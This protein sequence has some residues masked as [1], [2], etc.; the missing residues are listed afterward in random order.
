MRPG[1]ALA[2]AAAALG[3]V[4]G[5]SWFGGHKGGAFVPARKVAEGARTVAVTTARAGALVSRLI[6]SGTYRGSRKAVTWTGARTREGTTA[7]LELLNLIERPVPPVILERLPEELLVSLTRLEFVKP[8]REP[9]RLVI[10]SRDSR[11]EGELFYRLDRNGS[12]DV[13]LDGPLEM[14]VVGLAVYTPEETALETSY[15]IMVA[16][17]KT[18]LGEVTFE[19]G[20]AAYL[21]LYGYHNWGVS[22][23]GVFV[24]KALEGSHLYTLRG[25]RTG[26]NGFLLVSCYLPRYNTGG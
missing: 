11:W 3:L 23:P 17:D 25:S 18:E 12:L 10:N 26:D 21:S 4:L 7:T 14:I 15:T 9:E 8:V 19:A 13:E 1:G 22:Q 6:A 24:L 5:C 2:G 16:E 20:R